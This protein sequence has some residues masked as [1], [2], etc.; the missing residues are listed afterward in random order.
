MAVTDHRITMDAKNLTS[1]TQQV[2]S[3]AISNWTTEYGIFIQTYKSPPELTDDT[4]FS[5]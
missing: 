1:I 4:N 5:K 2:T 3:N